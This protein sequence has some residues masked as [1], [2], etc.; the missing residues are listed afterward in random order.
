MELRSCWKGW[1]NTLPALNIPLLLAPGSLKLP[2]TP[3]STADLSKV[4]GGELK[5]K[6]LLTNR[7]AGETAPGEYWEE[8]ADQL[9]L[10]SGAKYQTISL[11]QAGTVCAVTG[12]THTYPGEGLGF[13]ENSESPFLE[14][15]LSSR[16][17]LPEGCDPYA[18]FLRLRAAGG[19]GPP[20][21][22]G[23]E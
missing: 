16:M 19:R 22:P 1:S 14:P 2:G 7:P 20:A 6:A 5:V 3:R 18:V 9:R 17:I 21:P 12:L 8:K 15:V 10:Y 11:A 13:E 4:T 23:M